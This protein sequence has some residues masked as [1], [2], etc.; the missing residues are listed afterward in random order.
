MCPLSGRGAA[1]APRASRR[2]RQRQCLAKQQ[3][4]PCSEATLEHPPHPLP[5]LMHMAQDPPC[6]PAHQGRCRCFCVGSRCRLLWQHQAPSPARGRCPVVQPTSLRPLWGPHWP[7][8]RGSSPRAV[9]AAAQQP[10]QVDTLVHGVQSRTNAH[11]GTRTVLV[12]PPAGS[13]HRTVPHLRACSRSTPHTRCAGGA[14][15]LLLP[16]APQLLCKRQRAATPPQAPG[17]PGSA[18][19]CCTA[20][21]HPHPHSP[22]HSRCQPAQTH[23]APFFLPSLGSV[24]PARDTGQLPCSASQPGSPR[25][26]RLGDLQTLPNKQTKPPNQKQ[27]GKPT[28][29]EEK[30]LSHN[31]A[32]WG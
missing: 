22:F 14:P 17:L 10:F 23:G 4:D 8:Q 12:G 6:T 27:R 9:P 26:S 15:A 20:R 19:L 28:H 25:A 3:S 5:Q 30:A 1:C 31:S 29:K 13:P 16:C 18:R 2:S 32:V 24:F 11:Q 7:H 21:A